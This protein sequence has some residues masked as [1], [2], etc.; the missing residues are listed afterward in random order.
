MKKDY[1]DFG[2]E[3][4]KHMMAHKKEYLVAMLK[5]VYKKNIQDEKE[6]VKNKEN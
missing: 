3:W 5:E 1:E 4:E 2:L 6:R